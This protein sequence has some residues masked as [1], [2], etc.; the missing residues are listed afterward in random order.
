[1]HTNKYQHLTHGIFG[2]V[3]GLTLSFSGL[4]D[5]SEIHKMFTFADTRLYLLFAGAV[6]LSMIGFFLLG[7][8]KKLVRKKFN[9]GTLPGSILF[10]I[11]W[12]ITGACPAIALVQLGEGQLAAVVTILGILLGVWAFRRLTSSALQLD[13]GVCGEE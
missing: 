10:G 7:R 3:M 9:K 13:S 11:G 4:S 6:L 1:M 8:S 2:L 12:A 5:F